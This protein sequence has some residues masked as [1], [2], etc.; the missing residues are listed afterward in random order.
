M[1]LI[2]RLLVGDSG[3]VRPAA[4][5]MTALTAFLS[6][7]LLL[8]H[9]FRKS[10]QTRSALWSGFHLFLPLHLLTAILALHLAMWHGASVTRAKGKRKAGPL[11]LGSVTPFVTLGGGWMGKSRPLLHSSD[12]AVLFQ[13]ETGWPEC[14]HAIQEHKPPVCPFRLM[15]KF[16]PNAMVYDRKEEIPL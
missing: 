4:W 6:C 1:L 15:G 11:V 13:A 8:A 9:H 10:A 2:R 14:T 12:P 16:G 3:L 5:G 7:D